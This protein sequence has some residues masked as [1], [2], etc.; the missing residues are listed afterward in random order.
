M[1]S[2]INNKL[3]IILLSYYSGQRIVQCYHAVSSLLEHEQIPFEFII[4]DDGSLDNSYELA[5]ELERQ[6][7]HVKAYRLSRNFTSHYSI[8]AGLSVC[9]GACAMPIVDDEQ[10]PYQTIVDMYR[11]WEKGHKIIIPYRSSRRDPLLTRCLSGCYYK[12]M[13]LFSVVKYPPGGADLFLIDREVIDI[14]N[15]RIHPIN[16]ASITEVLRL[17]FAPY[18]Y[19]YERPQGLNRNKSRWSFG[20]KLRLAQDTF[21]SSSAFPII[22]INRIGLLIFFL[23]VIMIMFYLYIALW[24][25]HEFW[26]IKV[27][28]WI[29]IIL[30]LMFF[31]GLI[32]LSLGIIAEYIWRIYEE[33]KAR[34]GYIIR[35]KETQESGDG[36]KQTH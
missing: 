4:M 28:G 22:L 8:F 19:G 5:C 27:P 11:L 2:D 24:G 9:T 13:N 15:T 1:M 7:E 34:P 31:G 18:F 17:G 20:K 23:S 26:H 32:M 36:E 16:T 3:S 25:N 10:Q 6:H 33:V 12:V 30:C 29:S 21:L 35:A 14:L